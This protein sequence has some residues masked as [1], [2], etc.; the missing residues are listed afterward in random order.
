M[1]KAA[2]PKKRPKK[3]TKRS[4]KV[5]QLPPWK[6]ILHNDPINVAVDVVQAVQEIVKLL[7]PDAKKKVLEAHTTG[8][9]ILKHCH[10]ERAELYVEQ[11]A[12]C[13]PKI[14]VTTEKA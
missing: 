5:Q 9:S 10:Q 3:R 13:T 1:T 12:A 14:K 8:V 6:V 2:Q 4:K 11:F 7:P